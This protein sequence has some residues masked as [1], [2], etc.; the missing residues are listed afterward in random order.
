M[1]VVGVID[2]D[3]G[4]HFPDFRAHERAFQLL[5]QVSG[6]AGRGEM[7]EVFAQTL[8]PDH[9]VLRHVAAHDVD[10][11]LAD[12]LEQ[13]RLLGYPPFRRLQAV[14]VTAPREEL[15]D[16]VLERLATSLRHHLG[17]EELEILGPARAVLARINRRYRG[18]MLIKGNLGP[19]RKRWLVELFAEIRAGI[20][21]GSGVDLALDVDPLHLLSSGPRAVDSHR[22]EPYTF[23]T[24]TEPE[25]GASRV[26]SS[27]PRAPGNAGPTH[28]SPG[29]RPLPRHSIVRRRPRPAAAP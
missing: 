5:T 26:G 2:A 12:E 14:T 23:S 16:A 28:L 27:A 4:L 25:H 29:R 13:R 15:L 20:R 9:R 8:D 11:F 17:S 7:G 1:T 24:D 21:G 6:R 10:G 18:Q 22:G 19:A 3:Q